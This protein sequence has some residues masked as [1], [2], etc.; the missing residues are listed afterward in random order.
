MRIIRITE[1]TIFCFCSPQRPCASAAD[2]DAAAALAG[3]KNADC[4][5]SVSEIPVN[6]CYS[7][8]INEDGLLEDY[9][10]KREVFNPRRQET[11]VVYSENGLIYM[12]RRDVLFAE[13]S[14]MP[15]RIHALVTPPERTL[16]IDTPWNLHLAELI[17]RDRI[18]S[19]RRADSS[20]LKNF[21]SQSSRLTHLKTVPPMLCLGFEQNLR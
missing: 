8:L 19:A 21:L 13:H 5:V 3:E 15:A 4:V 10:S 14:L 16:D 9:F 11:P 20:Q 18:D 17:L 12:V 1:R 6:P 2:I 7:R